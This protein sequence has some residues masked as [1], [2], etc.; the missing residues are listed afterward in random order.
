MAA[1]CVAYFLA[2]DDEP[3]RSWFSAF[4]CAFALKLYE[5]VTTKLSITS[6]LWCRK[7][8][9]LVGVYGAE[10]LTANRAATFS[11]FATNA[12]LLALFFHLFTI[13]PIWPPS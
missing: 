3:I 7:S 13:G 1:S 4:F 6:T 11:Q 2:N 12:A 8:C 10:C 9:L 5:P